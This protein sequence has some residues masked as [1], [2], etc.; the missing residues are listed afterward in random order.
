MDN[1][2]ICFDS[3][4]NSIFKNIP[5]WRDVEDYYNISANY[6]NKNTKHSLFLDS[7]WHWGNYKSIIENFKQ[8]DN[9]K[10]ITKE[11]T[12][13]R[14]SDEDF[15]KYNGKIETNYYYDSLY[16][17]IKKEEIHTKPPDTSISVYYNIFSYENKYIQINEFS[18]P[19][20]YSNTSELFFDNK[21]KLIK[22]NLGDCEG[23]GLFT[24]K[25]EG[26][27]ITSKKIKDYNGYYH[28]N[29]KNVYFY[30]NRLQTKVINYNK[31]KEHLVTE[32]KYE[33]Y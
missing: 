22:Y 13:H 14:Y 21:G 32:Y 30:V 8:F 29:N 25:Y 27:N 12:F 2:K 4:F 17:I 16:R 15:I 31:N 6:Y 18:Y 5:D 9:N 19:S 10:N 26:E 3:V 20:G 33:F 24:L 23:C 28:D 11:I 7:I 1:M